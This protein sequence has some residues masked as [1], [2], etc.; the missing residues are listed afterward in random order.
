MDFEQA[1][2]KAKKE[3]DAA[4]CIEETTHHRG[5]SIIYG[6]RAMWLSRV[7]YLAELGL[8]AMRKEDE[9][10]H[11]C[12][13]CKPPFENLFSITIDPETGEETTTIFFDCD[14]QS[15][16]VYDDNPCNPQ[17]EKVHIKFCPKC[18]R[19]LEVRRG[20]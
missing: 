5:L 15:L 17:I 9:R 10:A 6:N 19:K 2:E 4:S 12:K 1:L 8:A 3:R 11:G 7:I 14:G 16:R 18:G 20:G 13:F